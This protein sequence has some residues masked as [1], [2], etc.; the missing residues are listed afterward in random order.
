MLSLKVALRY[1][2]AP[3]SH[4]AVNVISAVAV[5]GVAVAT[6]AI[7]CV[8]SVFNGFTG[9]AA[10]RLSVFDPSL[11]VE[12]ASSGV[13][14]DA[15]AVAEQVAAAAGADLQAVAPTVEEQALAIYADQQL[16]VRVKG[17]DSTY[18]SIAPIDPIIIDGEFHPGLDAHSNPLATLGVGTAVSLGAHPGYYDWLRL[19]VPRRRGRINPAN[20]M[21][22]FRGD[23]LVVSGV[24]QLNQSEYDNN[25][26]IVPID[27]ARRLLDYTSEASAIEVSLRPGADVAA[28]ASRI[29]D[30]LGPGF[31]VADR[32]QQQW[33]T[34]RMIEVE[35]WVTMALLVF[36]LVIASFNII[37]TLSM[38][39]IEKRSDITTFRALGA[40]RGFIGSIF[41]NQGCII[42]VAG[43][44]AGLI[45]GVG[46]CLLQEKFGFIKLG[47]DPSQLSITTYPVIV[48]A[49]DLLAVALVTIAVGAGVGLVARS[50]ATARMKSKLLAQ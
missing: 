7:V 32:L 19:Y 38:L 33:A 46:L 43:G 10:D 48:E 35:K 27:V 12:P 23:S 41:L 25:L 50:I 6:L 39:I 31:R 21:A 17:V 8:L 24:F 5:A 28:V 9:L 3:K 20:P 47:G 18:R 16:A 2:F 49:S 44:A 36:I 13:I 1:L 22:A 15:A 40:T 37:S 4:A 42:T 29:G 11:R 45:L 30:A 14:A 34:Y 26:V